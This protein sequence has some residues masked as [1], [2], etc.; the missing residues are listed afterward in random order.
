MP[1]APGN[2]LEPLVKQVDAEGNPT[3]PPDLIHLYAANLL[4][5]IRVG[6]PT[7]GV[8]AEAV[9]GECNSC[10]TKD[11]TRFWRWEES[12]IPDDP[13]AIA[14]VST[15]SRATPEPSLTPTPLPQPIV[16]IQNAP[17]LPDPVGLRAAFQ[18]LSRNDLFKDVTGLEGNQRNALSSFQ[19]ALETAKF[20]GGK[21]S[22]LAQQNEAARSVD[23]QLAQ[24]EEARNSD[25]IS[26]TEAQ[27]LA[28]AALA[29]LVR[30]RKPT[31]GPP[32]NEPAV[33]RAIDAAVQS[34]R[35]QVTV[36]TPS[37]SVDAA[38]E[39]GAKPALGSGFQPRVKEFVE[40]IAKPVVLD[41]VEPFDDTQTLPGQTLVRFRLSSTLTASRAVGLVSAVKVPTNTPGNE[42]PLNLITAGFVAKDPANP[43]LFTTPLKMRL[44]YPEDPAVPNAVAGEGRLPVVV[45]VHGNHAAYGIDLSKTPPVTAEVDNHV[46]YWYL[47][48]ELALHGIVSL[49]INT[50]LANALNCLAEERA[51]LTI[52]AL[53]FLGRLNDQAGMFQG[54]LDLGNVGLMGHS[55]GGEAVAVAAMKNRAL[56]TEERFGI[57]AVCSL[58][59]TDTAGLSAH[60]HADLTQDE[61]GFY[62]VLYGS[63]DGDVKGIDALFDKNLPEAIP[64]TA[65]GTSTNGTGFRLYDRATCEKAMIFARNFCHNRFNSV[66]SVEQN[67]PHPPYPASGDESGIIATDIPKLA[68]HQAHRDLAVKVIGGLFRWKLGNESALA[69]LFNGTAAIG[70]DFSLQWSFGSA[71]TVLDDFETTPGNTLGGTRTISLGNRKVLAS[72]TVGPQ[73]LSDMIP[74]QT[75]LLIADL[76]ASTGPENVSVV[77][78][79]PD[80]KKDW[81]GFDRLTFRIGAFYD[82]SQGLG[83]QPVPRTS[84]RLT[85]TAGKSAR[86]HDTRFLSLPTP[87]Y[88]HTVKVSKNRER[89]ATLLR[90]ETISVPLDLFV[91]IE[92]SKIKELAFEIDAGFSPSVFFD[93][94]QLVKM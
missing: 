38:F 45:L 54:R 28:H 56:P 15:E 33:S 86:V 34:E 46:G 61:T 87:P 5:P 27:D 44:V 90:M 17:E 32:T 83:Q 39:G 74:H 75:A 25:L 80:A 2:R 23:R 30:G 26:Q 55:R 36:T 35:G 1:L 68:T 53:K 64:A 76:T 50:N 60:S 57:R 71:I 43:A 88:P 47:Q 37:G 58:A 11:D 72:Q 81:S 21:A 49:S 20:F 7:R 9:M 12:P 29:S 65:G 84:I 67:G 3:E 24:I 51:N 48:D 92:R 62:L 10:E 8:Y 19:G 70:V 52:E 93:Q 73:P 89:I 14:E 63:L 91:G 4:P 94:I 78:S 66:W 69:G 59:P 42:K 16:N 18:L 77:E 22:E 6:V 40:Q 13:T 82:T 85:D 31:A 41:K 79:V